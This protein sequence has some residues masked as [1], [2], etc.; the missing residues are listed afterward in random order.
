M[1]VFNS[2]EEQREKIR[3]DDIQRFLSSY[4]TRQELIDFAS[5]LMARIEAL[6]IKNTI[7]LM[8]EESKR[9]SEISSEWVT[10]RAAEITERYTTRAPFTTFI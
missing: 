9:Q 1:L 2:E 10:V 8:P 3:K 6:E 5:N 4:A 7:H